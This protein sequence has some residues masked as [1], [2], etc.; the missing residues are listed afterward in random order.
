MFVPWMARR[1]TLIVTTLLLLAGPA[2]AANDA[3]RELDG[4]LDATADQWLD[5]SATS[6]P[7]DAALEDVT[8]APSEDV[9]EGSVEALEA[10]PDASPDAA[11]AESDASDAGV[12]AQ[13]PP[14]AEIPPPPTVSE[15]RPAPLPAE[16]RGELAAHAVVGLLALLVLAYVANHPRVRRLQDALGL[17]S[18]IAAGFPFVALG[19]LARQPVVN[20]LSE[21]VLVGL[22]P[23]I[24]F[25]LGWLGF[26]V[27]FKLDVRVLDRLP[28]GAAAVVTA[29]TVLPFVVISLVCAATLAALGVSITDGLFFRSAIVLGAAG[30]MTAPAA[31]RS[32]IGVEERKAAECLDELIG[33]VG[34]A[35]IAAY[36]RPPALSGAWSL[37][38]T[39][40]LFLTFG[41]GAT[42]GLVLY[43]ILRRPA[44]DPE[45][46]AIALGSIAFAAGMSAYLGLSP[47][48]ICFIAGVVIANLPSLHRD[49]LARTLERFE[50]PIFLVF[51]ALAGALWDPRD[52]RGWALLPA[53]IASRYLGLWGSRRIMARREPEALELLR[54]ASFWVAPLSAVAIAV[55]VNAR[56]LYQGPV[57][58]L[59]I[60]AVISGA[61]LSEVVAAAVDLGRRRREAPP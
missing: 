29:G 35:V 45:F 4:Q 27:G 46:A 25:G 37:P 57:V 54:P 50:R 23:L 26:L 53:F 6:A 1:A 11:V 2:L 24:E 14:Q 43:V 9:P 36:F 8:D 33:I 15:T 52:W 48:V 42:L 12:E 17:R 55:V 22:T 38:G 60:T 31:I 51:L 47:L 34:L 7:T 40:W 20:I 21:R 39:A 28:R 61:L 13:A 16:S 59:M 18:A 10:E 30:A 3:S 56:I 5:V 44:S 49:A 32:V 58:P 41:M 19:L